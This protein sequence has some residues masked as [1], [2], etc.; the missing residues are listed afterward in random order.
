[1]FLLKTFVLTTTPSVW[2]PH[3]PYLTG[4]L[5]PF[6]QIVCPCLPPTG[7]PPR[8]LP[9]TGLVLPLSSQSFLSFPL[10]CPDHLGLCFPPH[11]LNNS[12]H[13]SPT[14]ALTT[15]PS[16]FASEL[17]ALASTS[18][19]TTQIILPLLPTSLPLGAVTVGCCVCRS[20]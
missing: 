18:S 19:I 14:L 3:P 6:L 7:S 2:S 12:A 10:P 1:M 9:R 17:I 13:V 16:A 4:S 15:V 5:L 11:S 8:V 20:S